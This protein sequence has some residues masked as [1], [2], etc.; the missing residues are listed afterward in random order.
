[1]NEETEKRSSLSKNG[2]EEHGRSRGENLG[3]GENLERHR[4]E[5]RIVIECSGVRIVSRNCR[6]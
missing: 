6:T 5:R 3:R 1:M 2:T 4:A